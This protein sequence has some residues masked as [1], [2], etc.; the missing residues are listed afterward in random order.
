[1]KPLSEAISLRMITITHCNSTIKLLHQS[2]PKLT[3]KTNISITNNLTR[4]TKSTNP[5]FK[6]QLTSLNSIYITMTRYEPNQATKPINNSKN[7]IKTSTRLRQI[8]NKIHRNVIKWFTRVFNRLQ[9]ANR[10][11][12]TSFISLANSTLPTKTIN[13]LDHLFPIKT[14]LH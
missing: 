13:T 8:H 11:L 6:Q 5:V 10:P 4:H 7:R 1:M 9:Y 2:L 14:F 3:L 12:C